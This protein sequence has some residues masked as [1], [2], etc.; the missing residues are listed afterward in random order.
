ME[1]FV[2]AHEVAIRLAFFFAIFAIMATWEVL[3]P[4]RALTVS[5][6]VRWVN[7]LGLV[8]FNTVLLRLL[9]PAAAVGMAAF[10]TD[11]GWGLLNYFQAPAWLAI[12]IAVIAMDFVIWLQH[13]MVHAVP[14]LWRLQSRFCRAAADLR[15]RRGFGR[16]SVARGGVGLSGTGRALSW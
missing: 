8:A 14:A 12:P 16:P 10:T 6:A 13:V 5:K 9:F 3:A 15:A 7:N 11:Q 4:R 2:Q 1:T